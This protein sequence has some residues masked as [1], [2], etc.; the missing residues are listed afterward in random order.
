MQTQ[1][2]YHNQ[3][4]TAVVA[5]EHAQT[6]ARY[7]L[8][9]F[10]SGYILEDEADLSW[11]RPRPFELLELHRAGA[12][13][14]LPRAS[15]Q[16]LDP[17]FESQVNVSERPHGR[18]ARVRNVG[19]AATGGVGDNPSQP[20]QTQTIEWK[21]RWAIL[22]NGVLHLCKDAN[23]PPSH[24]FP[25]AALLELGG[26]EKLGL[27]SKASSRIICAKFKRTMAVSR[28]NPD[29]TQERRRHRVSKTTSWVV[30]DL[31]SLSSEFSRF[32][33][34]PGR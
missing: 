3:R 33:I 11:Y 15:P 31:P 22:R 24:K 32:L 5:P 1:T 6:S 8:F 10:S 2:F 17:Y 16:Y 25:L 14:P 27:A 9:S 21:S 13:V 7:T 28:M 29:D 23:A 20:A 18:R 4:P 26:P 12:I 30:L 34:I 19:S